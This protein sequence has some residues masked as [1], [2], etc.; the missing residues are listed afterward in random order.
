MLVTGKIGFKHE[1]KMSYSTTEN[2]QATFKT[3]V[4]EGAEGGGEKGYHQKRP[5]LSGEKGS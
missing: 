2:T 3:P 5:S 4:Q 1:L